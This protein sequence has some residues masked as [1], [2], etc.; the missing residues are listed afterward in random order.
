MRRL[1]ERALSGVVAQLGSVPVDHIFVF[2]PVAPEGAEAYL[3]CRYVTA[4]IA[5]FV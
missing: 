5:F 3:F 2:E 1:I 4:R